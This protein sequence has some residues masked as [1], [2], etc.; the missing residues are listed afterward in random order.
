L[1]DRIGLDAR[2]DEDR[3]ISVEEE[4]GVINGEKGWNDVS[5]G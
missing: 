3:S 1:G 5:S 4:G 2:A